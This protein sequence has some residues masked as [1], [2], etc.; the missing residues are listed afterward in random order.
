MLYWAGTPSPFLPM[1]DLWMWG[2]TPPPAMV[3]LIR[4]S[5]SSS[6]ERATHYN[7]SHIFSNFHLCICLRT[8]DG[9][10]QMAGGDP[11]HLQVLGG[12][13]SQLQHLG[14][15][16]L[17]DGRAVHGGGGANTTGSEAP[18]LEVTMDPGGR[19]DGQNR[20]FNQIMKSVYKLRQ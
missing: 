3:A 9:E 15:E 5:N 2:M 17:Q 10:L 11:L 8:S 19:D 4:V 12:V 1:R 13:A 6:P 7:S 18:A 16:I 14:G 20:H